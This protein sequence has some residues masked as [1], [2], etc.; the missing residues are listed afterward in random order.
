VGSALSRLGIDPRHPRQSA[1]NI[2]FPMRFLVTA[3]N[4]REKID[5]VRDWGNVF[6]GNTGFRIARALAAVGEV[7]LLTSNA[8][9]LAELAGDGRPP[10]RVAG[11]R[12]TTHAE[13]RGAL[14]A[15]MA[16]QPYDAVFMTAAVA[17]Y[18]PARTYAVVNRTRGDDGTETWTVR[19]AQAGKVKSTHDAVAVLGERT[20]KLVDL[21]RTEWGHRGLLV[22]FKLEVGV[23]PDDLVRIGQ[24]S[25]R[26]SGADYLVANT[27]DMVDG[28]DAGAFLLSDGGA[29]W[30][31]RD[32]LPDRLVRVAGQTGGASNGVGGVPA[33]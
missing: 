19:D 26:A 15:L 6:T 29:E 1:A 12:F 13:L 16:R 14:A 28:P 31:P 11:S 20:E 25:R 23:P 3:G 10:G 18:R 27:L 9:H 24:S 32:E 4:T 8:A 2:C 7:D 22:K 5:A 30:V 17:D 21:F 33:S